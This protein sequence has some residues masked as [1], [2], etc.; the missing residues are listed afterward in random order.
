MHLSKDYRNWNYQ[1]HIAAC[2]RVENID[3]ERREC[4]IFEG[5]C[6]LAAGSQAKPQSHTVKQCSHK[7]FNG[8]DIGECLAE[9]Q[10]RT[11]QEAGLYRISL[12]FLPILSLSAHLDLLVNLSMYGCLEE[13]GP[14]RASLLGVLGGAAFW[15][16]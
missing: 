1:K 9:K 15:S 14:Q 3:H 7:R 6:I 2:D 12:A 11:K 13:N 4:D 16:R 8:K 5:K 10:Q